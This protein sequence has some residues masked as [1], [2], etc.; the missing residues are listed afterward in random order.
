MWRCAYN[1]GRGYVLRRIMRRAIRY[2][3]QLSEQNSL[4]PAVVDATIAKMGGF[5]TEL[6]AQRTLIQR[7]VLDEEKRFLVTLDQGT[8]IL[9]Q[10]LARLGQGGTLSGEVLFKLYDTFGFPMDLTRIMAAEKGF[11]VDEA[12]FEKNLN[13]AKEKARSSWKG[14]GMTGDQAHLVQFAQEMQKELQKQGGATL[15]TGYASTMEPAGKIVALSTGQ[16]RVKELT[17][18]QSGI[19]VTDQTCFYAEGGG[20]VG[21]RGLARAPGGEAEVIDCTKQGEIYFHHLKVTD[22]VLRAGDPVQLI[23]ASTERRNTANNHSAT[24]LL[25]AALRLVLGTHVQQA[26]SLVEPER[27]RFDFT[28]NQPLSMVEIESLEKLVNAEIAKAIPVR[29][30]GMSHK[31]ALESGA[32]ALFGEK[33]GDEV[34]VVRMGD[35]SMELCGGIHVGNTS[36]IRFFKITSESGVS[37]GVRRIEALSGER[38]AEYLTGLARE[39]L[40]ARAQVGLTLG[41]QKYLQS[42][43]PRLANWIEEAQNHAKVLSREIQS[44]KGKNVDVNSLVESAQK[45]TRSGIQGRFVFADIPMDDRKVLSDLSDQLQDRLKDGVV[46]IVGQGEN[47]HPLIVSVSKS[48]TPQLNA[49]KILGEV[50]QTLGGKGGGRP[51]F[52]QGAVPSRQAL[53]EARRKAQS[54]VV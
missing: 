25:H 39:A 29:A 19:L 37:A 20:Q 27:L 53:E 4:L 34:R 46:V 32:M 14:K 23:V 33:Y 17:A 45:F 47:S 2:G 15:F 54:L 12:G 24:H 41:W 11:A 13:F 9:T 44:L 3:R 6:E 16:S 21:D 8:H 51:D 5:F 30:D 49:G 35:F 40:Q 38:A 50:A 1:E 28:H 26:G 48:L 36:Q 42:D 43:T 52:A 22:G 10:E 31:Q 18:E 7:T